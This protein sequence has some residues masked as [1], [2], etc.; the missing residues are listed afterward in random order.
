MA[1]NIVL[2]G[3]RGLP[4]RGAANTKDA[5]LEKPLDL[6]RLLNSIMALLAESEKARVERKPNFTTESLTQR[7]HESGK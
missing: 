5:F 2:P 4:P 1:R 6:P 3:F 7:T